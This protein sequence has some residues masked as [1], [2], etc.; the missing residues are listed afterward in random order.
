MEEDDEPYF[1]F[2]ATLRIGGEGLDL[3]EITQSM[4]LVPT[5]THKKGELIGPSGDLYS[6]DAWFYSAELPE[7]APLDAHLQI[8]WADVAPARDFLLALKAKH[9][10]DVFCG[11]RTNHG[12]AGFEVQAKSLAIFTALDI[13]FGVSVIVT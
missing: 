9:K 8:L 5:H 6:Q 11:Y 10:V 12:S 3:S 13:P 2:S 4:G 1:A 7:D